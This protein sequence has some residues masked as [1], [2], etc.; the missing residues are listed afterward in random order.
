MPSGQVIMGMVLVRKGKK[1]TL[2]PSQVL[3]M[4]QTLHPHQQTRVDFT[5]ILLIERN[6]QKCTIPAACPLFTRI[7]SY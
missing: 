4:Q 6:I 1:R 3:T 5:L 7:K 2:R